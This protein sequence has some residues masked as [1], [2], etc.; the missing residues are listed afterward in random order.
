MKDNK[1]LQDELS[2]IQTALEEI[3]IIHNELHNLMGKNITIN[4]K[5]INEEQIKEIKEDIL[6]IKNTTMELKQII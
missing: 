3:E 4:N 1:Y 2:K 6:T 5:V